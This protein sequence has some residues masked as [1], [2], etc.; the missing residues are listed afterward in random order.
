MHKHFFLSFFLYI[1]KVGFQVGIELGLA[2][3]FE[4]LA[5]GFELGFATLG[6]EVV[7]P[8]VDVALGYKVGLE[9][10]TAV[11][12]KAVSGGESQ[13]QNLLIL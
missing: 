12:H 2:E 8:E 7:G 3:G 13:A 6:F 5:V 11:G 1:N 9:V 4:G 10:G